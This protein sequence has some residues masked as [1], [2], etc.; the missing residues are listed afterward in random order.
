M[1]QGL[2]SSWRPFYRCPYPS[3]A[4]AACLLG[5]KIIRPLYIYLV[6]SL[7]VV[8]PCLLLVL[9]LG[10]AS[11]RCSL[12]FL[13]LLFFSQRPLEVSIPSFPHPLFSP[14]VFSYH[15]LFF[16]SLDF[17]SIPRVSP[18]SALPWFFWASPVSKQPLAGHTMPF[19]LYMSPPFAIITISRFIQRWRARIHLQGL[20][21]NL[22]CYVRLAVTSQF[23]LSSSLL[24]SLHPL[25]YES[26]SFASP[27]RLPAF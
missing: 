20:G 19:S 5:K 1:L 16:S 10:V 12:F 25:L 4:P 21:K 11:R 23:S 22:N 3:C 8:P 26:F 2:T 17:S 27:Y 15:T 7:D 18:P 14:L 24:D 9:S 6:L 13:I